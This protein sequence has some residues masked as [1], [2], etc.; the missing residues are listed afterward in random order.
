MSDLTESKGNISK[1]AGLVQGTLGGSRTQRV[2]I[3]KSNDFNKHANS[4][5]ED[6]KGGNDDLINFLE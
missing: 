4:S 5:Y 6:I 3:G 1:G 2:G